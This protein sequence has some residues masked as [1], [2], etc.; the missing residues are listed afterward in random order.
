MSHCT[1][2]DRI[3]GLAG[4]DFRSR[5]DV[6][7]CIDRLVGLLFKLSEV[8]ETNDFVFPLLSVDSVTGSSSVSTEWVSIDVMRLLSY[9]D[10]EVSKISLRMDIAPDGILYEKVNSASRLRS[11]R[12]APSPPAVSDSESES[13]VESNLGNTTG[14]HAVETLSGI[15]QPASGTFVA[16]I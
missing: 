4:L 11:L 2:S 9:V 3:N 8:C 13:E 6:C 12:R 10:P 5:K 16:F 15:L 1:V 14:L 7:T